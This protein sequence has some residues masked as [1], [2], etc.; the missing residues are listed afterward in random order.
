MQPPSKKEL[1]TATMQISGSW[2]FHLKPAQARRKPKRSLALSCW[3]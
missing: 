3:F 2:E 1:E